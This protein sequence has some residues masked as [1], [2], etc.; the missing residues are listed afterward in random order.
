MIKKGHL[1]SVLKKRRL[2][3]WVLKQTVGLEYINKTPQVGG[4]SCW[5]LICDG[6]DEGSR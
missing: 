2:E 6:Q 5:L 1:G 4:L 3:Y